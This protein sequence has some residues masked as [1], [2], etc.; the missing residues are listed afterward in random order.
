MTMWVGLAS[1]YAVASVPNVYVAQNVAGAGDGSGCSNARPISFFNAA[2]NWGAG[3][4][5]IGPGTIVHLCGT[6]AS[7]ITF[8]GSGSSGSPTTL[9]FEPGAKFSAASWGSANII[10][11][12]GTSAYLVIDG[13]TNG[14]IEATDN[15]SK[16]SY[17]HQDDSTAVDLGICNNCIVKN[18]TIS[19]MFVK[20]TPDGQGAGGGIMLRGSNNLI[21]NNKIHDAATGI[22]CNYLAGTTTSNTQ[23][24]NNTIYNVNWG[25]QSGDTGPGAVS[26]GMLIYHNDI[27]DGYMWDDLVGNSFHHNG[28]IV[29]VSND[30]SRV[31]G[32][33]IYNNYIHGDWGGHETGH[34]FLDGEGSGSAGGYAGA[35][36][37]NN[38]LADSSPVNGP[39]NGFIITKAMG[40][41]PAVG[42]YNNV[43]YFSTNI[44]TRCVMNQGAA[45]TIMNNTSTRCGSALY[46][47]A[48]TTTASDYNNWY[49]ITGID[50][51]STLA[52]WK[53]ATGF[54][55]H[56]TITD[57]KLDA[58]Y[59]PQSGSPILG[60]GTSLSSLLISALSADKEGVVRPLTGVWD[61]GV[62]Q[63][64]SQTN[65]LNPP[66]SLTSLV[67]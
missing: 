9:Q 62:F 57:P 18:L 41:S 3:A 58:N 63:F 21:Y 25:I 2:G 59:R 36:L 8:R 1:S 22:A 42:I 32:L 14:T 10:G 49:A 40:G 19:N 55:S 33:Q 17:S 54:D 51:Y 46:T 13:G 52:A 44:G 50:G 12:S 48:G 6:F 53:A 35:L 39:S 61:I 38:I 31:S 4:A 11:G 37:F 45:L 64:G 15:G 30:N 27:Y 20:N 67:H 66:T 23:I 65:P 26:S 16:P 24:Y 7:T 34:I 47:S 43:M 5:Q 60:T 28:V 56:S 29:W